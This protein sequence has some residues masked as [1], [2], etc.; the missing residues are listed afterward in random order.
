MAVFKNTQI[1][2]EY[3]VSSTTV[4]NWIENA[5]LKKNNLNVTLVGKKYKVIDDSHNRSELEKLTHQAKTYKNKIETKTVYI[6]KGVHDFLSKDQLIEVI[7]TLKLHKRIP[8]KFSYLGK[9]ASKWEDFTTE[10]AKTQSYQADVKTPELLNKILPI[11]TDRVSK[12]DKVNIVDLG[13]GNSNSMIELTDHFYNLNKLN[14]FVGLDISAEMLTISKKNL[15]KNIPNVNYV[16]CIHDLEKSDF[17]TDLFLEKT[18]KSINLI[19]F[20]GDTLGNMENIQRTI[21]NLR[22]SLDKDDILIISNKIDTLEK[23]T[24]FEPLSQNNPHSWLVKEFGIDI[25]LANLGTEFNEKSSSRRGYF[26]IDKDYIIDFSEVGIEEKIEL[27][28]GE[29]I[30]FWHH[31]MSS[32]EEIIDEL[33]TAGLELLDLTT[34]TDLSHLLVVCKTRNEKI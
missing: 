19:F 18:A 9:G 3:R 2:D 23:R 22:Y 32:R 16:N 8:M 14:K 11:L 25:D 28:K 6:N 20:V 15:T 5:I 17:A 33:N 29:K 21:E 1:S 26:K 10:T 31:K 34:T 4:L 24:Q 7:N 13:T 27:F 12:Y 30:V